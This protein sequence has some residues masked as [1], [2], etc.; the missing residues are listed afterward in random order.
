LVLP[1]VVVPVVPDVVVEVV[2]VVDVAVVDVIAVP[3]VSVVVPP[4][5]AEVDV[6]PVVPVVSVLIV[7]VVPVVAVSVVDIVEDVSLEAAAVSVLLLFVS[8]LQAKPKTLR[9]RTVSRTTIFLVI[10]C[11]PLKDD[12]ACGFPGQCLEKVP[13]HPPWQSCHSSAKGCAFA[14]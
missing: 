10:I 11:F 14:I 6:E 8:L 1:I 2:P 12:V 4:G 5:I 9:A 13:A 3:D 7:P